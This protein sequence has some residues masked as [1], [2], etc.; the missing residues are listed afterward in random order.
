MGAFSLSCSAV[1]K[2]ATGLD[3]PFTQIGKPHRL[4]YEFVNSMLH[5]QVK[6]LRGEDQPLNV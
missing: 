5:R 4:T 1:Y 2:A 3:L 6:E